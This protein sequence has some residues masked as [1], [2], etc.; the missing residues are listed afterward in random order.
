MRSLRAKPGV[1]APDSTTLI[2]AFNLKDGCDHVI[3]VG[4]RKSFVKEQIERSIDYANRGLRQ[5]FVKQMGLHPRPIRDQ[6]TIV[7]IDRQP[8]GQKRGCEGSFVA[9]KLGLI[10][11]NGP[12]KRRIFWANAK[13]AA[14]ERLLSESLV[15]MFD[16]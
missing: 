10:E 16:Q 11:K 3:D 15:E 14:R 12:K 6:I 8:F 7:R 13:T 1:T 5:K 2:E 4:Q 9:R